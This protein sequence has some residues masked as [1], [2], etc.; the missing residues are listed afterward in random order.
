MNRN[1]SE[2]AYHWVVFFFYK[3]LVVL[4]LYESILGG[5]KNERD[6]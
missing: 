1:C 6:V 5:R 2:A 3:T 4:D